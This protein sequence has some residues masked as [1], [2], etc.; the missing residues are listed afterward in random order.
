MNGRIFHLG[1][2]GNLC[3]RLSGNRADHAVYRQAFPQSPH[4]GG[5]V[6]CSAGDSAA[7][8]FLHRRSDGIQ[9]GPVPIERRPSLRRDLRHDQRCEADCKGEGKIEKSPGRAGGRT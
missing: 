8:E 4:T 7:G 6:L 2:L 9:R 5:G 3:R 1:N